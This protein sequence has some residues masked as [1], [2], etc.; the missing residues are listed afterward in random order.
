MEM[1]EELEAIR[2]GMGVIRKQNIS[3]N[4]IRWDYGKGASVPCDHVA[5]HLGYETCEKMYIHLVKHEGGLPKGNVKQDVLKEYGAG[6]HYVEE[7]YKFKDKELD[8][9]S[10]TPGTSMMFVVFVVIIGVLLLLFGRK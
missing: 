2:A 1:K 3:Y 5:K 7:G 4:P 8:G 6:G 9:T 10:V